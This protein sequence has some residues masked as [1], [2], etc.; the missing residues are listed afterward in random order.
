MTG[1]VH[2]RTPLTTRPLSRWTGALLALALVAAGAAVGP[3]LQT[4]PAAAAPIGSV[5][6]PLTPCR[7][8]DTRSGGGALV[9]GTARN[10]QVA[11][12]SGSFTSQGGTEGG[13]GVPVDAT[14]VEVAVSAVDPA[15]TGYLRIWPS[16]VTPP[17]AT[18]VN[19]TAGQSTTNT[20]AVT[21]AAATPDLTMQS[22][23]SPTDVVVDVQGYYTESGAG[24]GYQALN[25][26]RLLDTRNAGG[27]LSPSTERSVWVAGTG[28]Q[29]AAQGGNAAGCG[30]PD[31]ATAVQVS[32]TA[33]APAGAG[34]LRIRPSDV[35]PPN[36]TFVNF[37]AGQATTNTGAVT[38]GASGPELTVRGFAA[39]TSLVVDVQG[40]YTTTGGARYVPL[41]PCR[42]VDTRA[43]GQLAVGST[44]TFQTSSPADSIAAQGGNPAGCG[45]PLG[46]DAV[47]AAVSAV[48]PSGTGY[49]RVWP[50]Q[51]SLPN[52]TFVNFADGQATTNTGAL[53]RGSSVCENDDLSVQAFASNTHTV[54]DVQG[55]FTDG[56]SVAP[57]V[58]SFTRATAPSPTPVNPPA[59]ALVGLSWSVDDAD[60]DTLTCEL[61]ADGNG[62]YESTINSCTSGSSFVT[63]TTP[64]SVTPRI[65]VSDG[66][67]F[68]TG[69]APTITVGAVSPDPTFDIVLEPLGAA[70][71]PTVQAAFDAAAARWERIIV[72]GIPSLTLTGGLAPGTC[73]LPEEPGRPPGT[74]IDDLNIRVVVQPIDGEFGVLGGAGPCYVTV[75]D[76]LPRL[77]VM[78]FDSADLERLAV[79]GTLTDV[80]THEMAHVLG[81]GTQWNTG[82]LLSTGSGTPLTAYTGPLGTIAYRTLGRSGNIPLETGGGE[83]TADAHW[84]ESRFGNELMTGYIA[85]DDKLSVMSI[86]SMADL[87]YQVDI[88][89]ADA[90]TPPASPFAA[91]LA[92]ADPRTEPLLGDA[93]RR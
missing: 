58:C 50:G 55:Y 63:L 92:A 30:V 37:S 84:S 60:R 33:V 57:T 24:A 21:R 73:D 52:A 51:Q 3:V 22:F 71:S 91:L 43:T 25:P 32:V 12:D 14:A 86:A 78:V 49:M 23:T 13:C 74:V 75:P 76:A 80:I 26:C 46:A 42:V 70:F 87:G 19:Y 88:G 4:E 17:S 11:G 45:V 47:E 28:N 81:F 10:V 93:D 27:P 89:Q 39:A 36:A 29:L 77:G 90:Y 7:V 1:T 38:L 16:D 2:M 62:S 41:T 31:T 66:T 48:T 79:N 61:D 53:T 56:V 18:F 35:S 6:V 54:V 20:G 59:P 40:Y 9:P 15:G 65:R 72:K 34:F 83:G 67:Q 44:Q 85:S 5:Y 82:R 68:T 8:L 69:T 64:G